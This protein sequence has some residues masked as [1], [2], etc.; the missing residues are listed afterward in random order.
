MCS[1]EGVEGEIW[2][3][4]DN[5][6]VMREA[7][8]Q[9]EGHSTPMGNARML[10]TRIESLIA[11]CPTTHDTLRLVAVA[12]RADGGVGS[13]GGSRQHNVEGVEQG[14]R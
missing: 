8:A 6:A 5:L 9:M 11:S 3:I 12:R 10:G 4:T 7:E 2:V 14:S 1:I 13:A